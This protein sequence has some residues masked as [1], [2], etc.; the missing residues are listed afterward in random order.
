VG[1]E[2]DCTYNLYEIFHFCK[3]IRPFQYAEQGENF[4]DGKLLGMNLDF[5]VRFFITG[6]MM[7]APM[8]RLTAGKAMQH[9]WM[10]LLQVIIKI[11]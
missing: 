8:E 4:P 11:K 10:E 2:R 6:A 9:P 7:V 3:L 5:E 1:F